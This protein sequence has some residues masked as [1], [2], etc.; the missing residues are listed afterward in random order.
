MARFKGI[1]V[2]AAALII[3]GWLLPS[4]NGAS[5]WVP[6]INKDELKGM[7]GKPD[8]III[9]VRLPGQWKGSKLKVTGALH[10]DPGQNTE[11]WAA[12]YPKDKTIILYCS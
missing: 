11:S 6:R 9:D 1:A 3:G 4:V 2:F 12:K 5:A 8:V 7:L 10:E